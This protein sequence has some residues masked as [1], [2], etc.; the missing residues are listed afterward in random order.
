MIEL[1]VIRTEGDRRLARSLLR[2]ERSAVVNDNL[3]DGTIVALDGSVAS[4]LAEPGSAL[5]ALYELA[6][7]LG[8]DPFFPDEVER[9]ARAHVGSPGLDEAA[10]VERAALPF[11]TIDNEGSRDLDQAIH[12]AREGEGFVVRYALADASYYVRP[13]GALFEEALRRGASFYFPA[14]AI[15][16]LPRALSEG[17]VSLLPNV[18]RRALV[19][20][21]HLD[22][23]GE[24]TST[25]LERARIESRAQLTYPGVQAFYD[26]GDA[27]AYAREPWAESLLLLREV[28]ERRLGLAAER[29]VVRHRR[30][31]VE[32]GLRD[33]RVLELYEAVRTATDNYNEQISLLC[34]IEGARLRLDGA[35]DP[36]LHPV[37][38]VHPAPEDDRVAAFAEQVDALRTEHG[39]PEHPWRWDREAQSLARYLEGLPHRGS[40]A[41]VAAAIARQAILLNARSELRAEAGEHHGVGAE[42]YARFSA[43]MRE[44]VGI[45]LHK[46]LLEHVGGAAPGP[47]DDAL[48]AR[49]IDAANR[50]REIQ[51]RIDD[52][53]NLLA[54]DRLFATDLAK[55]FRERP[56]RAGTVM[57]VTAAKVYVRLDA[58]PIDIKLYVADLERALSQSL[59]AGALALRAPDGSVVA[60]VG[61]A[62]ALR[63][64][65]HERGRY[66]FLPAK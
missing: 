59:T 41:R 35:G 63:T 12:V 62:V 33:H 25:R 57:G 65:A 50:A 56:A 43:P 53:A 66:C 16:M 48:R 20:E 30:V 2:P 5:H 14:F 1:A 34:N 6:A 31:N 23:R 47:H 11:V 22:A 27:H 7:E 24:P 4:V 13:G 15:P 38:R 37:F 61:D 42:A 52:R 60:R 10:L 32:V 54:L 51:R 3:V 55:P 18:P 17:L 8:L 64:F 58:P 36:G 40:G 29:H 26:A 49:V 45:F 28:G 39:L 44:I 21:I 9:E 46:E 19:F